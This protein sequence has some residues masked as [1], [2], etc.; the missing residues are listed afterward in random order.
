[1]AKAKYNIIV[2]EIKGALD[3]KKYAQTHGMM[4]VSRHL[5][6]SGEEHQMYFMRMHEGA[7]SEGATR[8]RE[9][10]K[11]AQKKAHAIDRAARRP[12]ECP[13][14]LVAEAQ[15]WQERF[16]SY[17]ASLKEGE[18]GYATLYTYTYVQL[19]RQLKEDAAN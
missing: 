16:S 13:L 5:K 14:E 2:D 1:M 10:I 18:K 8:N 3:S 7:W 4:L 15:Q 9:L 19:Y 17:R 6:G 12:D 11:A